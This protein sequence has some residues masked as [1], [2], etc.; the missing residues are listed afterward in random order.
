M[1]LPRKH[2][3]PLLQHGHAALGEAVELE[4][5]AER[6]GLA[7]PE[8]LVSGRGGLLASNGTAGLNYIT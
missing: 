8:N 5:D 4:V 2:G 7:R 1:F 6:W 3:A